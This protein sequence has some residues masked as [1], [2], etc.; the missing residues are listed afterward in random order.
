MRLLIIDGVRSRRLPGFQFLPLLCRLVVPEIPR[1]E[2]DI[3]VGRIDGIDTEFVMTDSP[4]AKD[5]ITDELG[6][7]LDGIGLADPSELTEG[8]QKLK[9][10]LLRALIG[11]RGLKWT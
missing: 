8:A 5:E 3:I 4:Q 11:E 1:E 7:L 2:K 6:S 9:P 10:Q